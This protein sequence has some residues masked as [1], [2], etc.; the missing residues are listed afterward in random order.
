MSRFPEPVDVVEAGRAGGDGQ[1]LG[2]GPGRVH[3]DR[4]PV[5]GESLEDGGKAALFLG[6][7]HRHRSRMA[8]GGAQ[9]DQIGA[10]VVQPGHG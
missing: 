6:G 4:D 8:G 9:L 7:G 10:I 5:G 2:L 1:P 3:R